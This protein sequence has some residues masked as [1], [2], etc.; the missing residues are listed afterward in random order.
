MLKAKAIPTCPKSFISKN[1]AI[2]LN[3][4]KNETLKGVLVS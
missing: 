1:I 3:I 4:E 2:H